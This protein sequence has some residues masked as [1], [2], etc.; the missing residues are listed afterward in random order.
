MIQWTEKLRV[1]KWNCGAGEMASQ[2]RTNHI[3]PNI[4][5]PVTNG[6]YFQGKDVTSVTTF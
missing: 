2:A 6:I 1:R 4:W 5:N 3:F